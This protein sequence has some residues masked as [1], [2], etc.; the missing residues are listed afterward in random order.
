[1]HVCSD[2]Y[3]GSLEFDLGNL[4]A[5]EPSG[6][7]A[8]KFD[9]EK[10]REEACLDLATSI[11]QSLIAKVF[12]LPSEKA[13]VGRMAMLPPPTTP[14]PRA[15]PL[16]TPR[17]PTK[18]EIFAQ[19]KGIQKKKRS[20]LEYDDAAGEWRRR[21]GYKKANDESDVAIIDAADDDTGGED[22][23]TK[24]K[25]EKK[26]RVAKNQKQQVENLK[27]SV[28]AGGKGALPAGLQLVSD[29][30]GPSKERSTRRRHLKDEVQSH[31]PQGPWGLLCVCVCGG[32]GGG[33]QTT[34]WKI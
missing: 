4:A 8:A 14:L 21:H 29:L 11:T 10:T 23:F 28:K 19:Q 20:K 25:K 31:L 33:G 7:D 5:F 1:M 15:K 16:P 17:A 26:E 18:W 34:P 30:S 13:E 32:G 27:R 6:L 3:N 2:A 24:A 12:A 9:A 22:P